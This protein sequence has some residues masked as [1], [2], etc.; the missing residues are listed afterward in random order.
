MAT[1]ST[2]RLMIRL[3]DVTLRRYMP[4]R[5]RFFA[6]FHAPQRRQDFHYDAITPLSPL[7][8]F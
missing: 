6:A 7:R 4:P 2:P 8:L 1:I 3:S 5:R